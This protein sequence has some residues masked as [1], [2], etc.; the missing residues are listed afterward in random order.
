MQFCLRNEHKVLP[1]AGDSIPVLAELVEER[2]HK[3]LDCGVCA[4]LKAGAAA[5]VVSNLKFPD[6]IIR[7][8]EVS[9]QTISTAA[10]RLKNIVRPL[11]ATR[12]TPDSAVLRQII[13]FLN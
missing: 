4:A 9:N 12:P 7:F 10:A 6:A 8:V 13:I 3:A 5:V 1:I 11:T 2:L